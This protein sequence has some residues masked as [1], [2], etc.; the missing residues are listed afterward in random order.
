MS[1]G[2]ALDTLTVDQFRERLKARGYRVLIS[3]SAAQALARFQ[4]QPYHALI[5]DC[6]SGDR[7]GLEAFE[8]VMREADL[9]RVDCAGLLLLS[10]DQEHW[11]ETLEQFPRS[12]ALVMPV[13]MKEILQKLADL[14]PLGERSAA[15]SEN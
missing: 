15:A 13:K 3:I 2:P 7:T 8:R 5:V 12:A 9:K 10:K 1:E 14:A 4:Q 6:A 11:R